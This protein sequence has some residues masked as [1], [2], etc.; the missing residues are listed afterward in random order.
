M[1]KARLLIVDDEADICVLLAE[2]LA[3]SSRHVEWTKRPLEA[4]ERVKSKSYDLILLDVKMPEISGLEL[5][6]LLK[7][8]SPETVVLIMS[9][10]GN[11]P[12][13]VEAMK[14]GAEDY[15]E[16]PF[17]DLEE[18]RLTVARSLEAVS[19]RR[20]NTRLR[21]QLEDRF[22]LDNLVSASPKMQ[23]IFTLIKKVA[24]LS[25]TVLITGETG[26][27]KELMA[28]VL[29]QQSPR[30]RHPFICV[31]CGGLPEGLLESLLFGHERGAFT[32]AIAR[33][34]GY[35][36]EADSGT[37][38]LDEIGE[39][40]LLLQVKLLRILQER[41]FQRLGSSEEIPVDVRLLA[42][43]N[44]D[45][46]AEVQKGSFRLDLYYRLNVIQIVLPPLRERRE[47]VPILAHFFVDKYC[48][49][50]QRRPM[51][52]TK[53]AI[54]LLYNC[55]WPGN[56]RQLENAIE[57]AVVLTEESSIGPE[58]FSEAALAPADNVLTTIMQLPMREARA[59]FE[60][61]YLLANLRRHH[62][63]V[64]QAARQVG[65]PRQNFHR[66]M[67]RLGLSCIRTIPEREF[68]PA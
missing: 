7:K 51:K 46:E 28:R 39:M 9:A 30:S 47:D 60:K 43:T 58:A 53:E 8:A 42:A 6:P 16:K 64:T 57:R 25:T 22:Q 26:T 62:G 31:N 12:I 56:V 2:T 41:T 55:L 63:N 21:Q 38:F 66:K 40:P 29:H 45:L 52:L 49:A 10:F 32:D 34:R 1:R 18:V 65:L 36:E 54:Q 11:I 27:G 20:E 50:F 4:L 23:E 68:D 15:L 14:R 19:I 5:L 24:P 44:K 37:L 3:E 17:K 35:F 61:Q 59:V 33:T 67:K 48:A 13:A